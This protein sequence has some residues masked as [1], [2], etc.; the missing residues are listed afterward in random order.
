NMGRIA[1]Q[2]QSRAKANLQNLAAGVGEQFT[3]IL[4]HDRSIQPEIAKKGDDHLRIEAHG[5]LLSWP[6]SSRRPPDHRKPR[7]G[8]ALAKRKV[9]QVGPDL[10]PAWRAGFD[11]PSLSE[12]LVQFLSEVPWRAVCGLCHFTMTAKNE[13]FTRSA[14]QLR[15]QP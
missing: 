6:P 9:L 14:W 3:T 13:P 4:C 7:L 15:M 1:R 2:V 10:D 11:V 12:G 8:P 5:R